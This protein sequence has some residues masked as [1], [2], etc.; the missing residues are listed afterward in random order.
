MRLEAEA[1]APPPSSS[2]PHPSGP[3]PPSPYHSVVPPSSLPPNFHLSP[4]LYARLGLPQSSPAAD[5]KR[6]YRKL[7]LVYHP[8][9]GG[10]REVFDG[11]K[12]AYEALVQK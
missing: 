5:V 7:A 1:A 8:D 11:L 4:N 2:A 12:E 3:V 10:R 6:Q 9:K